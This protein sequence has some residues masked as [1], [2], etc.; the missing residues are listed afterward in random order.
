[1]SDEN[2]HAPDAQ[3]T[4]KT[5][6]GGGE[7]APQEPTRQD[8]LLAGGEPQVAPEA[9]TREPAEPKAEPAEKRE[10]AAEKEA[11]PAPEEADKFIV[12]GIGASAGGLEAVGE[13]LRYARA[14]RVAYIVVQ[15][16]APDHESILTQLL[17]RDA[18]LPVE[19][20]T[21]GKAL[22]P[23]RVYVIPPNSDLAVMHGVL[24]VISPPS[25]GARQPIDYLFRSLAEDQ[26]PFATGIV[27][28]GTGTDG[29]LGLQAIKAAGGFTF[30][31]DPSTAKYDGMPRSALASGAADYCLAPKE[32]GE[33]LE[34]IARQPRLRHA[35]H[36]PA[37]I[38]RVQDQLGKL[39]VL[40]RSEFGNDLTNYK[41]TTIDRR[42]E[43]RMTLHKIGRLDEYVKFVQSN[44]EELRALYKDVLITVTSFFRDP[45]AF[46][47]LKT[48]VFPQILQHKDPSQPIRVWVPACATG[49]EAYSV[50][51]CLLEFCEERVHDERIQ[52]FATDVDEDCIQF[53]RRGVYPPNI[54]LD[55]SPDRLNRF[56]IKKDNEY[57]VSRRIRDLLVFSRQNV[58]KDAPFSRIDLACCRNLLIYLQP[59]AQR[60]VLRVLHYSLNPSGYLL[61]GSSE[62]VGDAPDLFAPVDR[63]N[64][65]YLKKQV[66]LPAGLETTFVPVPLDLPRQPPSPRPTSSLQGLVDRKVLELYGP[67]GVVTNEELEIL[68]FR[69][70]TGPY[71]DPAPGAASFNLMRVARFELH[72]ELKR[73]IE[74]AMA[75]QQRATAEVTYP[76][77]GK[78][79]TVKLD[80]VP[81]TDPDSGARC[82][83]VLFHRLPPPREVPVV[84]TQEGE[85]AGAAQ[86]LSRIR[87]LE[88][89]LTVTK[90]YLQAITEEKESALEEL[91]SANEELQSSN[92][93]LQ[94]T[95]EELETSKEEMQSTNEELTTVNEELQNRMTELSQ[96]NDDLHNVLSG[97]ENAVVI[98]GMD[99]KMRRYTSA[100]EKL[101][102]LVPG[103]I[104]RSVGFLDGFLQ[105][106][107][108]EPKV[109]AVIQNLAMLDEEVLAANHRWYRL[110][111]SPYKTLDHAIRGALVTLTDVDVRKRSEE[112]TRDVGAYA[113]KFLAPIGHPLLIV[114]RK[115]RIVWTNETFLTTFQLTPDET[116]G[117]TLASVGTRQFA[118]A[119]LREH[120]E[121]VFTSGSV[122]RRYAMRARLPDGERA[123][124]VAGSL[125]PASTET[126]LALLSI[127]PFG[128]DASRAGAP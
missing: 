7:E 99:L 30:V 67:A 109:S 122:F 13:L 78:P 84:P 114:D 70:H 86:L 105:T 69:G 71:L 12:A 83:L 107:P 5:G 22:E 8:R 82:L 19:T 42:L 34:R 88:R 58:M 21:N 54:A 74:Q 46:E 65:I 57:Q 75:Q 93:E 20:A 50:A 90:E 53:A 118:D 17:G 10:E 45:E 60:K 6:S 48:S 3:V 18:R 125:V 64:K 11:Q 73:T 24:R 52:V 87:E 124:H 61:L 110:R 97:V 59:H 66:T 112:M 26:G 101:F 40:I 95:N 81:L 92:E 32:I 39:F 41:S 43:R 126:P 62:T 94:S 127:E 9:K 80:V 36:P 119:G 111:I 14:E 47:T 37:P 102:H 15:H 96:T 117:S 49:E 2:Q 85:A 89:E 55:V 108:L 33:E 63:K 91:K 128:E 51:M 27:L 100:A 4:E 56:F 76:D 121:A 103:D 106:T 35:L 25:Y 68:Q 113:G 79:C 115:Q 16:L 44:R 72:I 123:V 23:G 31:Q 120:L 77:D 38:E 98:V 28:S 104:G 116:V 29:T 1:M